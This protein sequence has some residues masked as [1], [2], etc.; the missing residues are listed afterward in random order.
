M[1][2]HR[3]T[4]RGDRPWILFTRQSQLDNYSDRVMLQQ[5]Q[6]VSE[7]NEAVQQFVLPQYWEPYRANAVHNPLYAAFWNQG[8]TRYWHG[9]TGS[10]SRCLR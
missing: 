5:S 2:S 1:D 3:S 10:S 7:W 4:R 9:Y 6:R 8:Y